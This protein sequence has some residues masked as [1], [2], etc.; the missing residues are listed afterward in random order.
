[1]RDKILFTTVG[2]KETL[3]NMRR[4]LI[5][6]SEAFELE[7][8]KFDDNLRLAYDPIAEIVFE[9]QDLTLIELELTVA[10]AHYEHP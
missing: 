4:L 2:D 1:M 8:R 6:V 10:I 5:D 7:V 3:G 9:E